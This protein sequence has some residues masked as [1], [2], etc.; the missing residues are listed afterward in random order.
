MHTREESGTVR[1]VERALGILELLGA[2]DA[3]GLEELHYL[4][5][6]PKATVS[7]LLH[8]LQEQGWLYRGLCDRRYRLT[9]ER[10]F[11]DPQQR[12]LRQLVERASPLLCELAERTGLVAD[13]SFFDGDDLLVVES[14]VPQVLRRRYPNNRLVVG[15]K[16]SLHQSAMGKACVAALEPTD[17][18]R[19]AVR[20]G[21]PGEA[22]QRVHEQAHRQGYGERT[23]GSWE[24]AVRLPFLIRAVAL[25]VRRQGRVVGSVALHW[26]RD[27]DSVERVSGQHLQDLAGTVDLLQGR[28]A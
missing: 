26:P 7:R 6:L 17:L 12:F 25:P 16:A 18:E 28:L 11:G 9:A 21:L 8:T 1:S 4:T 15:L 23:E 22:L 10:L 27:Q 24:Y 20:H 5:G 19:L 13:L 3:L 14:A 2:H